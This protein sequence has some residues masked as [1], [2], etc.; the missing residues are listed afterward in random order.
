MEAPRTKARGESPLLWGK[1]TTA[2]LIYNIFSHL[3]IG[4]TL[5]GLNR[6]LQHA[7]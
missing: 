4:L 5:I 6:I 2:T 1:T 3:V 7:R